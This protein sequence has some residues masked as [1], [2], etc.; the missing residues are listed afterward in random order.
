VPGPI[1]D[2]NQAF[3]ALEAIMLRQMLQSSGAFKAGEAAGGALR[4]DLFIET[5][6]DAVTKSGGLGV[7]RMLERQLGG[8][9][10]AAGG[11]D[12]SAAMTVPPSSAGLGLSAPAFGR[13]GGTGGT[14]AT[15]GRSKATGVDV[16][17]IDAGDGAD[18]LDDI[19]SEA[20]LPEDPSAASIDDF[21]P[22]GALSD[23]TA[24]DSEFDA[25]R[26]ARVTQALNRYG[27]RADDTIAG[28][29]SPPRRGERP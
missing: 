15:S 27:R 16:G 4:R 18:D 10:G 9:A 3:A 8:A 22:G 11:D 19:N 13:A 2:K 26:A 28:Y 6:A 21:Q 23:R 29:P 25:G 5:L 17:A 7:A 24:A 20:P 1:R 12:R 14:S